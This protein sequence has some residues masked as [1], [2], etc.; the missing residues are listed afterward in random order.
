[1]ITIIS[2]VTHELG[3]F[4]YSFNS[5]RCCLIYHK[6]MKHVYRESDVLIRTTASHDFHVKH[7]KNVPN[8]K[9][10]YG[11]NEKSILRNRPS[12]FKE[13]DIHDKR[14]PG[15]A[16]KKYCLF[17]NLSFILIDI[18]DRI[19]C[20]FLYELLRQIWDILYSDYPKS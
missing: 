2:Y 8:D 13:K 10:L 6:D 3:G 18:V 19:P 14:V 11:V 20:W 15:E 1:M 17:L 16:M 5:G 4:T 12:T 7:I 9:S